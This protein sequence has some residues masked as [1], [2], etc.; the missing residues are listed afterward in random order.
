[1]NIQTQDWSTKILSQASN[2][3]TAASLQKRRGVR[4]AIGGRGG[5][6]GDRLVGAPHGQQACLR[7]LGALFGGLGGGEGLA[8]Q[9]S[10]VGLGP[11]EARHQKV[12]EGPQLQH[13][14]LDG[15]ASQNEAV[16]R[17][18]SLACLQPLG[19]I[20]GRARQMEEVR[21]GV[22]GGRGPGVGGVSGGGLGSEGGAQAAQG[23]MQGCLDDTHF[24]ITA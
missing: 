12:E 21:M 22:V 7:L 23:G 19:F 11:E 18:H 13:V 2:Q 9:G 14:V 24:V 3:P 15:G 4:R 1:M 10:E 17:Y 8:I 6:G 16:L 5:G 20:K